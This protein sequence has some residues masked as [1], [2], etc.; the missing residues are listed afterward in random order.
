MRRSMSNAAKQ[1]K[2]VGL[3]GE[4]RRSTDRRS[5]VQRVAKERRLVDDRGLGNA[6]VDAL[7]DIL[8][9]ER[10]SERSMKVAVKA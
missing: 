1:S 5:G 4:E 3:A 2:H 9:W 10:A 8:A 6:M 7:E